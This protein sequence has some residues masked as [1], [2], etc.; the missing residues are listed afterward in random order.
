MFGRK[1]DPVEAGLVYPKTEKTAPVFVEFQGATM[2]FDD[3]G[4][5]QELVPRSTIMINVLEIEGFYDHTIL[6]NGRKL[7]VME[8]L[9]EIRNKVGAAL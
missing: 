7:R 8:T 5:L 6:I 9:T 4:H 2:D 1:F 3:E